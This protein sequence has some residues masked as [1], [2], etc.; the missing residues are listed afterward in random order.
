[1]CEEFGRYY[2]L[3]DDTNFKAYLCTLGLRQRDGTPKLGW[4]AFQKGG[5]DLKASLKA[6]PTQN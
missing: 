6:T 5:A 1:M 3:P 2:G 4:K